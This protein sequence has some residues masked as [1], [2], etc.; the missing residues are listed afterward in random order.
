M[1]PLRCTQLGQ[2]IKPGM[3]NEI[4]NEMTTLYQINVSKYLGGK[5][6]VRGEARARA[7]YRGIKMSGRGGLG[8]QNDKK[9]KKLYWL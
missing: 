9:S 1:W 8:Y 2:V 5:K 4:R 7:Y 3:G 6:K